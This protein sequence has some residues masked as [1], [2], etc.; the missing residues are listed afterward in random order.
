MIYISISSDSVHINEKIKNKTTKTNIKT[1]PTVKLMKDIDF[2]FEQLLLT[3]INIQ[4]ITVK[5]ILGQYNMKLMLLPLSS[6]LIFFSIQTFI[7]LCSIHCKNQQEKAL[8]RLHPH[9]LYIHLALYI[10]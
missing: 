9:I 6:V 5:N 4:R 2:E 10:K 8:H 3:I 1:Y 7:V